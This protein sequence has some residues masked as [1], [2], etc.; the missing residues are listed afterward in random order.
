MYSEALY[1]PTQ[2][3]DI[4]LITGFYGPRSY[5]VFQA[6]GGSIHNI[7]RYARRNSD[8]SS[9]ALM[10]ALEIL[11]RAMT[12]DARSN[13]QYLEDPAEAARYFRTF[14]AGLSREVFV[15]AFLDA[16]HRLIAAE[17]MFEGTL[18]EANLHPREIVR[19][20]MELDSGVVILSHNHP[21]G[22]PEPSSL[23]KQIT[24]HLVACLEPV[25]IHVLDHIIVG[26]AN[27]FSFLE[28]GFM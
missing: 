15:A 11:Q 12:E 24:Q 26:R 9:R 21:S 10:A 8:A 13:A 14:L 3:S 28:R 17:V 22:V 2:A 19:R 7:I 20:A 16:K 18:T 1:D 4:A 6:C 25:G 23:D 27:H 5:A